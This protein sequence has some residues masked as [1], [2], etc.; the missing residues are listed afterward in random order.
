MTDNTRMPTLETDRLIIRPYEPG[1]LDALARILSEDADAATEGENQR[2]RAL[3]SYLDW[4]MANYDQLARLD[5]P[6]YGDRAVVRKADYRLIGACALVPAMGPFGQLPSFHEHNPAPHLRWPE[7]GLFYCFDPAEW[8]RGYASEAAAAL[9]RYGFSQM[10]LRR[11]IATTAHSNEASMGVMRR[12]GMRIERNLY[13]D[14]PWFQVV[15]IL[16]DPL[17][18]G[19]DGA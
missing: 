5:Q 16:E 4:S 10:H 3:M 17:L 8:R 2:R 14:P 1:D 13:P 12:L 11:I 15:G 7:V 19:P 6:P 18:A 9:V